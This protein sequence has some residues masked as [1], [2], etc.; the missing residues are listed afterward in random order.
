MVGTEKH[1]AESLESS[2]SALLEAS[3]KPR[4]PPRRQLS[5]CSNSTEQS[6]SS[7]S[8]SSPVP[9]PR[10][11]VYN[12]NIGLA[13]TRQSQSPI[14]VSGSATK[15]NKVTPPPLP[16]KSA[17]PELT[18]ILESPP[19]ITSLP[20]QELQPILPPRRVEPPPPIPPRTVKELSKPVSPPPRPS[21]GLKR[22]SP[23]AMAKLNDL[24]SPTSMTESEIGELVRPFAATEARLPSLAALDAAKAN[25]Y[26]QIVGS[27]GLSPTAPKSSPPAPLTTS[28]PSHAPMSTSPTM[29]EVYTQT[30]ATPQKKTATPEMVDNAPARPSSN[31][32]SST[33]YMDPIDALVVINGVRNSFAL[34]EAANHQ[35]SYQKRHSDPELTSQKDLTSNETP[36]LNNSNHNSLGQSLESLLENFRTR[37]PT[38][39]STAS[40]SFKPVEIEISKTITT[41]TILE[42]TEEPQGRVRL[43]IKPDAGFSTVDSAWQWHDCT[44]NSATGVC[45]SR[46]C[47][48][49]ENVNDQ[50]LKRVSIANSIRSDV[51]TIEDIISTQR[52][53]LVVPK[54]T[55]IE[56][57][58]VSN[59]VNGTGVYDNLTQEEIMQLKHL[60]G[61]A[62]FRSSK[63]DA[64][65]EFSDPWNMEQQMDMVESMI[66]SE[67]GS[68]AAVVASG[69]KEYELETR[70][71]VSLDATAHLLNTDLINFNSYLL[72]QEEL[73]PDRNSQVCTTN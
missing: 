22:S 52:P 36:K 53:E 16:P 42:K 71:S 59:G 72:N 24:L 25:Y 11:K 9:V 37:Y 5:S 12:G 1:Q 4:L 2:K 6:N 51:T 30:D 41:T 39:T 48:K 29:C 27:S 47:P 67:F 57:L 10:K 31:L 33:Y 34:Q 58:A 61:N 14:I 45:L 19:K 49:T 38:G 55:H 64:A 54:V 35:I 20:V 62:S 63:S 65:T 18:R 69:T 23:Q 15:V 66:L 43:S 3:A 32:S 70:D 73:F 7:C 46:N 60:N 8:T 40:H 44:R 13:D 26:N 50:N 21:A 28:Q 68:A 17:S 56:S